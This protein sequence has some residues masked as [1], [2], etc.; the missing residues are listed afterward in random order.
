MQLVVRSTA[1]AR[2]R[3]EHSAHPDDGAIAHLVDVLGAVA[4]AVDGVVTREVALDGVLQGMVPLAGHCCAA[5]HYT[6]H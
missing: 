2:R 3:K 1:C 6:A 4:H 5:P